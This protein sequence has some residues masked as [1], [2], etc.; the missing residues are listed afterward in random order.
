M[1]IFFTDDEKKYIVFEKGKWDISNDCPKR[2]E[3]QLKRK[4]NMIYMKE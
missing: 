1:T 2:I 4:I 3:K